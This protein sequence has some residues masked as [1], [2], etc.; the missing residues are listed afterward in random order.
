MELQ[1]EERIVLYYGEWAL[2]EDVRYPWAENGKELYNLGK[3]MHSENEEYH[4]AFNL[5]C[6]VN[7]VDYI[8]QMP[9]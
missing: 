1:D 5:T 7:I 3:N 9:P 4:D 6:L 8:I 2:F